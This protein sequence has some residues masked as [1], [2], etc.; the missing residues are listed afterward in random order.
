MTE[1]GLVYFDNAPINDDQIL[2]KLYEMFKANANSK[3]S[4]SAEQ[5]ALHG[6]VIRVLDRVRSSGLTK[7]GY[8]IKAAAPTGSEGTIPPP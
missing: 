4:I 5:Q 1:G 2:P 8:Q 6:D 7:I 3:V